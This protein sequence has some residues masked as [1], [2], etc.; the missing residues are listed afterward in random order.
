MHYI[1]FFLCKDVIFL[2]ITHLSLIVLLIFYAP[3]HLFS[4]GRK[5]KSFCLNLVNWSR[6]FLFF[7][8]YYYPLNVYALNFISDVYILAQKRRT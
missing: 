4:I 2:H 7:F 8:Y 6:V 1:S 3:K 5:N